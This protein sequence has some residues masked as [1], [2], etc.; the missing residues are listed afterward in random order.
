MATTPD[1]HAHGS[2]PT[3][4]DSHAAHAPQ[5]GSVG[6]QETVTVVAVAVTIGVVTLAI[7]LWIASYS[8]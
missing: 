5:L 3:A 7:L 8:V 2:H 6:L 4:T 1:H